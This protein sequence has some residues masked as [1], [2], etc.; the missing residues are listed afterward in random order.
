MQTTPDNIWP[1]LLGVIKGDMSGRPFEVW[2]F[3]GQ[4]WWRDLVSQEM[5]SIPAEALARWQER[6]RAH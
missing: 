6:Q 1:N 3:L 5:I 2:E 4:C